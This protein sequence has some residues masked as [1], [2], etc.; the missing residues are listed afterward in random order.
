[1]TETI[2]LLALLI[3]NEDRTGDITSHWA[4]AQ[5]AI[6]RSIENDWPDDIRGILRQPNQFPWYKKK[7]CTKKWRSADVIAWHRSLEH[8]RLIWNSRT[9]ITHPYT[10]FFLGRPRWAPRARMTTYGPH[11]YFV[12]D[13][14]SRNT[15]IASGSVTRTTQDDH[16]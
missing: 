15:E 6:N 2:F 3:F 14:I 10:C 7:L 11:R 16:I 12:C 8:A 9:R 13:D 5:T 4:I 1:M